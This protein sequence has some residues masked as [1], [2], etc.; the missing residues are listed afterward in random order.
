MAGIIFLTAISTLAS[1]GINQGA[2]QQQAPSE[3]G[4]IS[5]KVTTLLGD[6]IEEATVYYGGIAV[7]EGKIEFAYG[8]VF[9][10]VNGDYTI[11]NLNPG[12]YGLF[13]M[14]SGYTPNGRIVH[15]SSGENKN[16]VDFNLIHISK[17][18]N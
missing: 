11:P 8:H 1:A 15:L 14:K 7:A 9:T 16:G 5:G 13:V 4:S 17:P 12:N 10:D 6:P 3:P 18:A 2:Q